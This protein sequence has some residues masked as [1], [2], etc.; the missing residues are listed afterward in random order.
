MASGSISAVRFTPCGYPAEIQ[1]CNISVCG[2]PA[3]LVPF[4]VYIYQ[5]D[6]PGGMPGTVLGGPY[7][8]TPTTEG[9][10]TL[11][12]PAPITLT[13]GSFYIALE[14]GGTYPN[15]SG[16]S[17]D[18]T[19]NQLRS[20]QKTGTGPWVPAGGNYMIRAV[21][22]EPCG[23]VPPA[24]ISYTVS[25]LLLGQEASPAAWTTVGT[26]TGVN[27]INDPACIHPPLRTLPL[28]GES[29]LSL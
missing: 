3:N 7:T 22:N 18:T 29:K 15:L 24:S 23:N 4:D 27:T 6:G 19:V 26:V 28:G 17:V 11:T 25:R 9:W 13:G 21:V 16:I 1:S 10:K 8:V 20:F 5:D 2:T 14:L 12:L